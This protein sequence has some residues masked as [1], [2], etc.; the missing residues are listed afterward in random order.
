MTT[1]Q[2]QALLECFEA[3]TRELEDLSSDADGRFTNSIREELNLLH[4]AL[5]PEK[6]SEE[7]A[8]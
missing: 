6:F 2:K 7:D 8:L 5:F 3:V 4:A 1:E